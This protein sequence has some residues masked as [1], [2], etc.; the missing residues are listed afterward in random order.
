M[1]RKSA[2]RGHAERLRRYWSTGGKGGAKIAWGV[3]HDF[4]R[5]RRQV[6]RHAHM[7]KRQASGY[8][9]RLHHRNV[10]RWPGQ[11]HHKGKGKRR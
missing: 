5:C 2:H 9:A 10:G 6:M 1:V 7:S 11:H 3:P 4:Y 8:C